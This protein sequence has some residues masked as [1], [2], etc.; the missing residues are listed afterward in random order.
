[1]K[2]QRFKITVDRDPTFGYEIPSRPLL[3]NFFRL[4]LLAVLNLLPAP[5]ARRFFLAFGQSNSYRRELCRFVRTYRALEILYTYPM[6]RAQGKTCHLDDFWDWVL[7]NSRAVRNRLRLVVRELSNLLLALSSESPPRASLW[8][9]SLGSG[10]ARAVITTVAALNGRLPI[11]IGLIDRSRSAIN[12]SAELAKKFGL[13]PIATY[14]DDAENLAKYCKGERR[15]CLVEM[16]GLIDY[17]PDLYAIELIQEIYKILLPS[18]Y[19]IT[20][21]IVPNTEMV[22]ITKALGWRMIY[23]TPDDLGNLLVKGGFTHE[24]ITLILEPLNVHCVAVC[25]KPPATIA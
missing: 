9:W 17:F 25:R 23:R 13:P 14:R 19:L 22:F 8:L 18:G 16:V 2:R 11:N 1:M 10:S 21:N 3:Q 12:F 5:L 20:C 24:D 7:Y 4:P 15:P 6:L